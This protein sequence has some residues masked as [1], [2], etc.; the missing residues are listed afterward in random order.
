MQLCI[1]QVLSGNLVESKGNR[2]GSTLKC[3]FVLTLLYL[4]KSAACLAAYRPGARLMGTRI[5]V[6][7]CLKSVLSSGPNLRRRHHV[8]PSPICSASPDPLTPV[9]RE[10]VE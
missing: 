5:G 4:R 10:A 8:E 2:S 1:R 9:R 3:F 7:G 6:E